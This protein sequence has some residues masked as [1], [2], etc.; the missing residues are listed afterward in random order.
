MKSIEEENDSPCIE[1]SPIVIK[2]RGEVR[3]RLMGKSFQDLV[4]RIRI[5]DR[6]LKEWRNLAN[7]DEN[8]DHPCP[9]KALLREF[10]S[11]RNY[12]VNEHNYKIWEEQHP[13]KPWGPSDMN[14]ER[15]V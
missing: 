15:F 11:E 6:Y 13:P 3:K 5:L 9:Y 1:D 8:L 4:G 2:I 12:L 10:S 14:D 7:Y